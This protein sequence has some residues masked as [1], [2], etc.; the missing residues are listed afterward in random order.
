MTLPTGAI[1]FSDINTEI[2]RPFNQP[3]SLNDGDVRI[4]AERPS[5]TISMSDLRGKSYYR[6]TGGS[7]NVSGTGRRSGGGSVTATSGIAELNVVGGQA[8]LVYLWEYISGDT[9]SINTPDV[10]TTTFRKSVVISAGGF[11]TYIGTYRCKVTDGR[12]ITLYGPNVTV[13]LNVLD[14]TG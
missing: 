3:L 4:V 12:G 13:T 1:S 2:V 6:I 14:T 9:L 7:T 8:P 11:D 10:S 5:G